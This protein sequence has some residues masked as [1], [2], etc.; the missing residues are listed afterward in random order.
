MPHAIIPGETLPGILSSFDEHLPT[1]QRR[2][3]TL[4]VLSGR[5]TR[6]LKQMIAAAAASKTFDDEAVKLREAIRLCIA[7]WENAPHPFSDEGIEELTVQQQY[8]IL[9][10]IPALQF[11]GEIDAKKAWRL[12]QPSARAP[13]VSPAVA[14]AAIAPTKPTP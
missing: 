11:S 9:H 4:Y 10:E 5:Q 8:A 14:V 6:Q 13:S 2:R 3:F 12:Q 1:E 7:G